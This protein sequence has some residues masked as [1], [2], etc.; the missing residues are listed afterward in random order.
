[1]GTAG[2]IGLLCL[3]SLAVLGLGLYW[4][5]AQLVA[6]GLFVAAVV[7][8]LVAVLFYISEIAVALSSVREEARLLAH[9]RIPPQRRKDDRGSEDEPA[10]T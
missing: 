9:I 5:A 7:S 2:D 6:V 10:E 1:M 4:P 8:M 3:N